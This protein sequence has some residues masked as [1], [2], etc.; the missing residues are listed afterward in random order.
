[1]MSSCQ[2]NSMQGMYTERHNRI[3]CTIIKGDRGG[4]TCSMDLESGDKAAADW[5][6]LQVPRFA[7]PNTAL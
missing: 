2:H 1:M 5:V 7:A 6:G 4:D 3:G